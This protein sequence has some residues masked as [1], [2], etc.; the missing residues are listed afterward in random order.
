[1]AKCEGVE[2]SDYV[3][4]HL[5]TFDLGQCVPLLNTVSDDRR[6]IGTE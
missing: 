6:R 3:Y 4:M 5:Q 1:M 2:I